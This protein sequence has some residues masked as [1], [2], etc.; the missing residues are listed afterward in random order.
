MPET[1]AG[2][3]APAVSSASAPST[4]PKAA[5]AKSDAKAAPAA[6]AAPAKSDASVKTAAAP[7]ESF[8]VQLAA[9]SDDKGA[10]ALAAKLKRAGHAAYVEPIQ[11]ANKVTMWRVRVGG[12]PTRE[13]AAA[14]AAQL[15]TEGHAG[16]IMPAR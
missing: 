14:A 8:V 7:A 9:F 5:A 12:F 3:S 10:N 6:V 4:P 1:R 15:K 13:A 16:L 11:Q 2:E